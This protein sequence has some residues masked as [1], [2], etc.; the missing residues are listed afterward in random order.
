MTF[1]IV[2][3]LLLMQFLWRYIDELVGKG[4]EFK[5]IGELM[6]YASSSLVPLA[7]PLAILLSSLMT[8]GNM[9]EFYELTAMKSSGISLRRIMLPLVVLV[10]FI[11]IAAFVFANN[12]LPVTNLKMKSLLYDVRNQRPEVQIAEGLFYNGIDNFSIRVNKKN[13]VNNM[14]YDIKIYDHSAHKG[15]VSVTLA[16]SGRMKMT[17][18]KRNLVVTLWSGYSYTEMD[19]KRRKRNRNYPHRMDKFG[20]QRIIIEMSGFELMRS[21]ESLFRNSY[22]M[23]NL[24]QLQH[25]CDSLQKGLD[26]KSRQFYHT[27]MQNNYF[28]LRTW[29]SRGLSKP[30]ALL[31]SPALPV[32]S[33]S[34]TPSIPVGASGKGSRIKAHSLPP[35]NSRPA[36]ERKPGSSQ[37]T[38][39]KT[40]SIIA[41]KPV[42][43]PNNFDSLFASY[44]LQKKREIVRS[45]LSN[46]AMNQFLIESTSANIKYDMRYLRRHEIEWH[47]KFT[48]SLACLIFL[49][50]GAPLGAI[51]RKGGLGMPTVISTLLFI[52]YYIISLTG[53]KFVRES[54]LSGFQG[55]WLSSLILIIA[56]VFLTYEATNDSAILNLDSYINWIRERLGLRKGILL[57]E[58]AHL[59]G[60]FDILDIPRNKLQD[61]FVKIGKQA[62]CC[63]ELLS[64]DVNLTS[65]AKKTLSNTGYTYLSEFGIDYNIL[66][67][68]I[69]LSKWFRIP[70]FHKRLSEFPILGESIS[71]A[72]FRNKFLKW[73]SFI[74]F[75]LWIPI[76]FQMWLKVIRLK[77]NLHQVSELSSGMVNLLNSAAFITETEYV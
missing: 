50:I 74:L 63:I 16:D 56:G 11:S 18:D 77:R 64:K 9:G 23:L 14:L 21:D 30:P 33:H 51:I 57:D 20:E 1:F 68:K 22:S 73:C 10:F 36:P 67:D 38:S 61:E 28:K 34:N 32:S 7:L 52:L 69:I 66:I 15:N 45:A 70:Y 39:Q 43:K 46:I 35:Q 26:I 58:K 29:R 54:V 60:K 31:N 17:A 12:V 72:Y 25:A 3:F 48:L 65:L 40:D 53:E 37:N 62:N 44:T 76:L 41:A 24:T 55:M 49:F 4:L 5:I 42:L 71:T 8:F 2:L 27:M 13:P 19:E 75:P 59:T 6:A 47:R